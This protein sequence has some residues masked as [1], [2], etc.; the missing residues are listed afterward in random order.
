M[1]ISRETTYVVEPLRQDGYPDYCRALNLQFSRCITS[2]NNAVVPFWKAVGPSSIDEKLRAGYLRAIASSRSRLMGIIS[3][4]WRV[5]REAICSRHARGR[6]VTGAG[7][8]TAMGAVLRL[9]RKASLV[10][11]RVSDVGG[12]L[13]VNQNRSR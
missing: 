13:S 7:T 11:R 3:S 6:G 1:T 5:Y 9:R 12:L 8:K 10:R 2:E 4:I